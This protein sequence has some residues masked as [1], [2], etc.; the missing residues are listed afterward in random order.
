MDL[1]GCRCS[2]LK[3]AGVATKES[4]K[5]RA[6][7]KIKAR[8]FL[9]IVQIDVYKY[10]GYHY[11]TFVDV[12]TGKCWVKKIIKVNVAKKNKGLYKQRLT[13]CYRTWESE[14]QAIPVYYAQSNSKVERLHRTLANRERRREGPVRWPSS[15]GRGGSSTTSMMGTG[16]P[17]A[18]SVT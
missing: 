15:R 5:S 8:N 17:C 9:D 10:D 6:S 16:S 12:A 18:T 7:K 4:S 2:S 14:L 3:A 1:R 11:L 13:N